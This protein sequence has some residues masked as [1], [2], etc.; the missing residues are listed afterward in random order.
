LERF[1]SHRRARSLGTRLPAFHT[2][3]A[4]QAGFV[5]LNAGLRLN[6]GHRL[7]NEQRFAAGLRA[8]AR[9]GLPVLDGIEPR[10]C[11]MPSRYEV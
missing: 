9:A 11:P 5:R 6:A 3:A 2:K 10:R 1:L 8:R 7:A 4:G